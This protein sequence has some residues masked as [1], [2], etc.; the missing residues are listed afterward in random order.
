MGCRRLLVRHRSRKRRLLARV[1]GSVLD[2][3]G[4]AT[5]SDHLLLVKTADAIEP[6]HVQ[7]LVLIATPQEGVCQFSGTAIDGALTEFDVVARWPE[8]K[9]TVRPLVAALVREGLAEDASSLYAGYGIPAYR[10]TRYGRMFLRF[11]AQDDL[12]GL[13]LGSATLVARYEDTPTQMNG[14]PQVIVRNI[15][16]G[17]ARNASVEGEAGIFSEELGMFDLEPGD[18]LSR[19]THP[20]TIGRGPPYE[21]FLTWTDD[22]GPRIEHTVSADRIKNGQSR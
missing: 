1:V 11:L 21:V 9:D 10:P 3:S 7:L 19:D 22:R 17:L 6:P 14:L 4:M 13:R 2:G 16:P 15:G 18:E 20:A 12:G 5:P 8:V